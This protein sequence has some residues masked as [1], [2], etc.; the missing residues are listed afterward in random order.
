[1]GRQD[2]RTRLVW[3]SIR[4]EKLC[5]AAEWLESQGGEHHRWIDMIDDRICEI[6]AEADA[7]RRRVAA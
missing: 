7:L 2:R 3:L 6:E 1:M 5:H 4:Y